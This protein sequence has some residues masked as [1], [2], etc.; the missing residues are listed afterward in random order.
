MFQITGYF[1]K[2][3]RPDEAVQEKPYL[4]SVLSKT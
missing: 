1:L 4:D 2:Y 3:K